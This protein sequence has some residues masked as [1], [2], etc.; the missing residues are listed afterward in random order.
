M[1]AD[2]PISLSLF[3]SFC[4]YVCVCILSFP[5]ALIPLSQPKLSSKTKRVSR[6]MTTKP[7]F[8]ISHADPRPSATLFAVCQGLN[9]NVVMDDPASFSRAGNV[10]WC[11]LISQ[12][13]CYS[14]VICTLIEVILRLE[15][16]E[17][18]LVANRTVW[19]VSPS[20]STPS[21]NL[22]QPRQSRRDKSSYYPRWQI[23]SLCGAKQERD[24]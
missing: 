9:R 22:L 12:N 14:E 24:Q 15:K 21:P 4:V 16:C 5:F 20:R 6:P 2:F 7:E 1:C 19:P 18:V 23:Y 11:P 3:L 13:K 8:S 17:P 10:A